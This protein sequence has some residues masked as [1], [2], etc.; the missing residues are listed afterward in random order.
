MYVN[1]LT[2]RVTNCVTSKLC[3]TSFR[4]QRCPSIYNNM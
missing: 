2:T 3:E 1:T 4:V